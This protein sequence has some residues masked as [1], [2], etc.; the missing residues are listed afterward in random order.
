[1]ENSLA[2]PQKDKY[3][4]TI[5]SGSSTPRYTAKRTENICEHKSLCMK[6]HG[7]LIHYRENVETAQMSTNWWMDKQMQI[8]TRKSIQQKKGCSSD[9]HCKDALWPS[10]PQMLVTKTTGNVEKRGIC[11]HGKLMIAWLRQMG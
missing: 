7:S 8:H 3:R 9:T 1:M 4:V 11:G 10:Y 5:W 6:A 2:A